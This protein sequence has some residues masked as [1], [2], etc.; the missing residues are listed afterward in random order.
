MTTQPLEVQAGSAAT[1]PGL[2]I[3]SWG[4]HGHIHVMETLVSKD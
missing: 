4:R 2:A 1:L 3:R